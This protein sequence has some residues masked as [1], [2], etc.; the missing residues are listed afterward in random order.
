MLT[1]LLG[2]PQFQNLKQTF[3]QNN[4]GE[5]LFEKIFTIV[6]RFWGGSLRYLTLFV[7]SCMI[8]AFDKIILW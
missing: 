6:R 7:I 4:E 3:E 2:Q 8:R 1:L 5:R